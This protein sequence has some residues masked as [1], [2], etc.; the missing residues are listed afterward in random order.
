[1]NGFVRNWLAA[2]CL[3]VSLFANA[4]GLPGPLKDVPRSDGMCRRDTETKASPD[5][6]VR[7]TLLAPD[8]ACA[9]SPTAALAW[10]GAEDTL[11][12]DTR[13]PFQFSQF[14]IRDAVNMN[15]GDMRSKSYLKSK[16][17]VL[18]G[19]GKGD[20]VLYRECARLRNDGFG[21]VHVLRGGLNTWQASHQPLLGRPPDGAGGL[22]LGAGELLEEAEFEGNVVLVTAGLQQAQ[23]HLPSSI[24]V[25]QATSRVLTAALERRS[26]ELKGAPMASLVLVA[27]PGVGIEEFGRLQQAILP[28]PLLVY[29]GA[30]DAIVSHIARQDAVW[31]AQARGPRQPSCGL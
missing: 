31:S 10:V 22:L 29:S 15:A 20:Y 21:Q 11:F 5:G 3:A 9:V 30:G 18:F 17:L 19:S 1:M 25:P 12:V 8:L 2:G 27:E 7:P 26:K 4:Q 23:R 14:T 16:R 28:T 24:L 13:P 6:P